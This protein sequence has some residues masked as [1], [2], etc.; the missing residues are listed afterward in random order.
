MS[1]L[2]NRN[3]PKIHAIYMRT[4]QGHGYANSSHATPNPH[5]KGMGYE[6]GEVEIPLVRDLLLCVCA[7]DTSRW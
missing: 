5:K 1:S 2:Q 7:R 4:S 3:F 6:H